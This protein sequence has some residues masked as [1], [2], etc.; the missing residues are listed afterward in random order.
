MIIDLILDRKDGAYYD[1]VEFGFQVAEYAGIFECAEPIL[2]AL[3][4]GTEKA[5]KLALCD[6]ILSNGYNPEICSYVYSVSWLPD[7]WDM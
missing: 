3:E 2:K 5:V 6:Y 7:W 4:N 1:P